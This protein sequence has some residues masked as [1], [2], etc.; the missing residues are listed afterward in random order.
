M[1][2]DAPCRRRRDQV[3]RAMQTQRMREVG[4]GLPGR[5]I[6]QISGKCRIEPGDI[7][8]R[9]F[10]RIGRKV[11]LRRDRQWPSSHGIRVRV[12]PGW[13][14]ASV[15]PHSGSTMTGFRWPRRP[16][17]RYRARP[18]R[19]RRTAR[20]RREAAAERASAPRQTDRRC[21]S[22]P[23]GTGSGPRHPEQAGRPVRKLGRGCH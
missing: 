2:R 8:G 18:W 3:Q 19:S 6:P 13:R 5:S 22:G 17:E 1:L 12:R 7:G 21:R 16:S 9:P 15:R 14:S 10:R 11:I 20:G 23:R 4:R